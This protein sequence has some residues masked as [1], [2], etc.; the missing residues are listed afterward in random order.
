RPGEN[1]IF[2]FGDERPST[3][4]Q[5][6]AKTIAPVRSAE[7]LSLTLKKAPAAS[8][9]RRISGQCGSS[10]HANR[11]HSASAQARNSFTDVATDRVSVVVAKTKTTLARA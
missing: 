2:D 7:S 3:V 6:S 5:F 10:I 11:Q 9:S 8:I 1:T 4:R